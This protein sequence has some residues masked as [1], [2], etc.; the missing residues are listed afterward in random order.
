[1]PKPHEH[2]IEPYTTVVPL[3]N[4]VVEN[5]KIVKD[6]ITAIDVIKG[7]KCTGTIYGKPCPFREAINIQERRVRK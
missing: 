3:H 2:T 4:Y 6:L 1:M 7:F 5:G